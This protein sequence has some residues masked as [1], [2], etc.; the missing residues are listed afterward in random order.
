MRRR[1][2]LG[3]AAAVSLARPGI[4]QPATVL[5]FVPNVDLP[6][7]DPIANTAAQVRNHAFLVYDTLFGLDDGFTPQPQMLAEAGVSEIGVHDLRHT[8]STFLLLDGVPLKV[9]S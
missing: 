5:R 2:F 4:A 3:T 8:H 7:L 1:S 6:V 9:V